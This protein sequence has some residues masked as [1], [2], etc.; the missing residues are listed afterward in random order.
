VIQITLVI[1]GPTPGTLRLVQDARCFRR[2]IRRGA[3]LKQFRPYRHCLLVRP[4]LDL[5]ASNVFFLIKLPLL[6][7]FSWNSHSESSKSV[8]HFFNLLIVCFFPEDDKSSIAKRV[9]TQELRG[10][11]RGRGG[12][13]RR[14]AWRHERRGLW[15]MIL[16][17][18]GKEKGCYSF[19]RV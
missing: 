15:G 3:D 8:L 10:G 13:P 14:E 17:E 16:W 6:S 7:E 19:Y 4:S 2:D 9:L 5:D 1:V 11:M 12:S 18:R